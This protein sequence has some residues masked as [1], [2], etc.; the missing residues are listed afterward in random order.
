MDNPYKATDPCDLERMVMDP[1]IAKGE[2]GWWAY[3]EINRLRAM[4]SAA[5][6]QE[7]GE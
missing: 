7:T 5:P 2:S 1:N 6:S 4:I 3:E